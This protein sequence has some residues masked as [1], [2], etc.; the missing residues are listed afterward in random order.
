MRLHIGSGLNLKEG[1]TNVDKY[2]THPQIESWD[3]LNLPIN[4]NTVELVLA[5]HLVEHLNFT[6]EKEFFY[7]TYRVLKPGGILRIEVPDIEW[8]VK[9]FLEAKDDFKDFYMVGAADHYF[10][11]GL[12][13]DNRWSLLTT[14]IWGN[15]NGDGQFHK[16]GYTTEKLNSIAKLVGFTSVSTQFDFKKG[17]QVIVADFVK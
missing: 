14:A 11:N 1:F 10:G 7:E 2:V 8:V 4:E 3:I 15:Q 9:A 6:E 12:A 16:N 17:T 13:I 5:E